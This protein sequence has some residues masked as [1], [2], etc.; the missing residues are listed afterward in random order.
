MLE[1]SP[2]FRPRRSILVAGGEVRNR[3]GPVATSA[4]DE[5]VV[6]GAAA[7]Q[8]VAV[9]AVEIVVA[10]AGVDLVVAAVAMKAV[11]GPAR[12]TDSRR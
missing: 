12:R 7:Q 4:I 3:V 1:M 11:L 10:D 5:E 6:A 8:V 2:M 9:A